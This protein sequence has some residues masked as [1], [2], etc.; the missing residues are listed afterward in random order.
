[1]DKKI[2]VLLT[3]FLVAASCTTNPQ[4]FAEEEKHEIETVNVQFIPLPFGQPEKSTLKN[5]RWGTLEGSEKEEANAY[6]Q[7]ARI[8]YK[9]VL[10]RVCAI[11]QV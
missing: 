7:E 1:M 4:N 10:A 2:A 9:A 11:V 6:A 8:E 3:S 5:Y